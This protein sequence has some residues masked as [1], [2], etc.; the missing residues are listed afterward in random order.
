MSGQLMSRSCWYKDLVRQERKQKTQKKGG[1][2]GIVEAGKYQLRNFI[3]PIFT[4][5]Q[6]MHS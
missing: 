6:S 4:F 2:V 3:N 1:Y 5:S